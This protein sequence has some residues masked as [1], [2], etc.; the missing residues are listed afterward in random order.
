MSCREK[1]LHLHEHICLA[2][3]SYKDKIL[4]LKFSVSVEQY[5]D[6]TSYDDHRSWFSLLQN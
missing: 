5:T 6:Y 4:L 3:E 1:L 2:F